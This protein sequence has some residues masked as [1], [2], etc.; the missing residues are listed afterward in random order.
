MCGWIR[1]RENYDDR[2]MQRARPAQ[3]WMDIQPS[4]P[5]CGWTV[6]VCPCWAGMKRRDSCVVDHFP[7]A[8][9]FCVPAGVCAPPSHQTTATESSAS[10][11]LLLA[12]QGHYWFAWSSYRRPVAIS[13]TAR[14]T[15]DAVATTRC[16]R[17]TGR[18]SWCSWLLARC[19]RR[20]DRD[21]CCNAGRNGVRSIG[22][23]S[24]SIK[25]A[26]GL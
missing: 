20:L 16:H 15:L 22:A 13:I 2:A 5:A 25:L 7:T 17:C 3:A 1:D 4:P 9:S 12:V 14:L 19:R 10:F 8:V 23:S 18:A 6:A 21:R 26:C 11:T 24:F